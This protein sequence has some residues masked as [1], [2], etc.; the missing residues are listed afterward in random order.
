MQMTTRQLVMN[1]MV[2]FSLRGFE[3]IRDA[4]TL[5]WQY[6]IVNS[7][8]AALPNSFQSDLNRGIQVK[9]NPHRPR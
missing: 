4:A 2:M 5:I 6:N 7:V 1:H 8:H 9:K 3:D